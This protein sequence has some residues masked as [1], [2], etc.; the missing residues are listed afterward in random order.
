MRLVFHPRA[1]EDVNGHQ[2]LT[3]LG[4]EEL[5]HPGGPGRVALTQ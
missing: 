4:H 2:E 5:T 1:G 3:H